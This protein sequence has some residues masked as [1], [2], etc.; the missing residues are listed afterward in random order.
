M[1]LYAILW[2]EGNLFFIKEFF[3]GLTTQGKTM[4]KAVENM[5]EAVRMYLERMPEVLEEIE[6]KDVVG[7]VNIE[8]DALFDE[9]PLESTDSP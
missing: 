4:D 8:I 6:E 7:V 2:K 1:R 9:D 3:T 5:R